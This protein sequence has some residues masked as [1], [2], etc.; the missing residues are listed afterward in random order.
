MTSHAKPGEREVRVYAAGE[1]E[2]EMNREMF[3]EEGQALVNDGII[4]PLIIV[5]DEYEG[6]NIFFMAF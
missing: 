1:D 5:H 4:D 2:M 6:S 3:Q